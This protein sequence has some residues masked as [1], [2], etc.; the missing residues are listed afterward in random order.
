MLPLDILGVNE[1]AGGDN[2]SMYLTRPLSW[3]KDTGTLHIQSVWQA[4]YR[5]VVIPGPQNEKLETFNLTDFPIDGNSST[6]TANRAALRSKLLAAATPADTDKDRLPDYWETLHF[7]DLSRHGDTPGVHGLKT[8]LHF[9]HGNKTPATTVPDSLPTL[10]RRLDGPLVFKFKRRCGTAFGLTV[11]PD[12]SSTLAT[13]TTVVAGWGSPAC[14][15]ST[16]APAVKRWNGD[17]PRRMNGTSFASKP[18][19]L[20]RDLAAAAACKRA[21]RI[22]ASRGSRE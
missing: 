5:D 21:R 18:C 14:A 1:I 12:F 9:A 15:G 17:W 10:I 22:G 13:W 20:P 4:G 2:T 19:S 7:G 8:L 3:T 11:T 6:N 16:T